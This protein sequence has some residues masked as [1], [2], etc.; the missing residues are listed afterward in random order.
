MLWLAAACGASETA[1]GPGLKPAAARSPAQPPAAKGVT[2]PP[3]ERAEPASPAAP[4]EARVSDARFLVH[5]EAGALVERG[6]SDA[7]PR[8][9]VPHADAALYD[10]VLELLWFIE[11]NRLHVLD[12]RAR[13][14][15][16]VLIANDMQDMDRLTVMR[17][18]HVAADRDGCEAPYAVLEWSKTPKI[19]LMLADSNERVKIDGHGWLKAQLTRATRPVPPSSAF[20]EDKVA[21]PDE[22]LDCEDEETCAT[23]VPFADR[24]WQLVL[25]V[26]RSGGDCWER[27]CLLR[28]P[29]DRYATPPRPEGWAAGSGAKPGPCGPYRFDRT[30]SAYLVQRLLCAGNAPCRDVGGEALGWLDP[31]DIVGE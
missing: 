4:L 7:Q 18:Q 17:G 24:G 22:L 6:I 23:S 1:H 15:P 11:Q 20:G 26:D 2:P 9:L 16:P 19:K 30:R 5:T 12:L 10:P 21:V 3:A 8:T 13:E 28:N 29:Q 31:G 25:V 27:A 14:A